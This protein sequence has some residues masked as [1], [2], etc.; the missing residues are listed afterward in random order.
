MGRWRR[1]L[2][3]WIETETGL[4]PA[5]AQG[6]RAMGRLWWWLT[7]FSLAVLGAAA[8]RVLLPC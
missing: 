8:A 6:L 4:H 2:A 7:A 3:E 1:D 5:V